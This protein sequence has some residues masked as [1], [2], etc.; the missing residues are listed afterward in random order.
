MVVD[1][2]EMLGG[3]RFGGIP[4]RIAV[5]FTPK[6]LRVVSVWLVATVSAT[7][8]TRWTMSTGYA[9]GHPGN[10]N[11]FTW[12]ILN[13]GGQSRVGGIE[14][15][16][17]GSGSIL[18]ALPG[19][20]LF[21]VFVVRVL[22]W[23]GANPPAD[24]L[25]LVHGGAGYAAM[26]IVWPV[27]AA[28]AYALAFASVV[29]LLALARRCGLAGWRL[30][31][32]LVT[33]MGALWWM[34]V[35]WGHP[36][37][38]VAIGLLA[39][40]TDRIL[41][42]HERGAAWLLGV[43]FAVQPLVL[44]AAPLLLALRPPRRWLPLL[45]RIAV[46]GLLAVAIPLIGD[47]SDTWRQVVEQPT[48]PAVGHPTPWLALVPHPNPGVVY[49]GWPRSVGVM[50]ACLVALGL[51]RRVKSRGGV[52]PFQLVWLMAVCL[53]LRCVF[54]SVVFPYYV[55]PPILFAV[56]AAAVRSRASLAVCIV[57]SAAAAFVSTLRMGDHLLY[58]ILVLCCLTVAA[59]AG[60]PKGMITT[61]FRSS[62]T[63]RHR[64]RSAST[65][66]E[67]LLAPS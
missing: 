54:E 57:A 13:A 33:A 49:A 21:L 40:A 26:G 16:Y 65:P 60:M 67:D 25:V 24:Q 3:S 28:V 63:T 43:A 61:R 39:L 27:T 22:G 37:D 48:Y 15:L 20:Q 55:V 58:W 44:L 34:S 17:S 31:V 62:M 36:D 11:D 18:V 10:L 23:L 29:P 64:D 19:F 41:E 47:P 66:G 42:D 45:V 56:L 4:R 14:H 8:W 9:H 38:A 52:D 32:F 53:I 5:T 35:I 2:I 6:V 50:L 7:L 51:A 12:A 46:P 1:S 59:A 30:V